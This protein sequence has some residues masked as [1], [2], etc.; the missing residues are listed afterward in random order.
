MQNLS[1]E[2]VSN[3]SDAGRSVLR[4]AGI[5]PF[6]AMRMVQD[7]GFSE[8]EDLE[9]SHGDGDDALSSLGAPHQSLIV[10]DRDATVEGLDS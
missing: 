1:W 8:P 10:P 4:G 6:V 7:L 5:T 3:I 2:D 9:V